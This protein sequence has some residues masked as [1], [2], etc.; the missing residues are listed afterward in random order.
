MFAKLIVFQSCMIYRKFKADYLFT[1]HRMLDH[2]QVLVTSEDGV[3]EDIIPIGEATDKV[4]TYSGILCPGFINC[5][6]HL[7]LSHLRGLIPEHTGLT[8]FV[9]KVI[10]QQHFGEQEIRD[11]IALAEDEMLAGGIVGVGDICNNVFS[12]TQKQKQILAYYNFI[13]A[14][15][16]L[17]EVAATRF[18]KNKLHYNEFAQLPSHEDFL[19]M[20]PHA[21]YSV[22]DKLWQLLGPYFKNKTTSIHNQET[23]A[24]DEL[25]KSGTGDLLRMYDRLKI[26]N[27][28][29]RPFGKSSLQTYLPRL[30]GAKNVLLVHNSYT[31]EEDLK[32]CRQF[33]K[34]TGKESTAAPASFK[35]FFCLCVNANQYIENTLPPIELFR[36]YGCSLVL[37]TDSLASNHSLSIV[38]EIKTIRRH[39]PA[40]PLP[41]ILGWATINGARALQ[42]DT[43][44]GSFEPGK[45]PGILLIENSDGQNMNADSCVRRIL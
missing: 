10:T 37:G 3:V 45:Q 31:R 38:D 11:A 33:E 6:C 25:F 44:Y 5:H 1:G 26:D 29:F 36:K 9:F 8:D 21:S 40:L 20:A 28:F 42:M 15:G 14:S 2:D 13:E 39:F 16:W 41:E 24:E 17:P 12:F 22:S 7:E 43:I 30:E 34:G 4:E 23:A 35:I 27:S 18:E 32:Y 19:A